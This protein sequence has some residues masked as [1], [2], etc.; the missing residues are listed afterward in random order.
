[1]AHRHQKHK[2]R[3][4]LSNCLKMA[5]Q[6]EQL[7]DHQ[8][9][10]HEQHEA[11]H[12]PERKPDV[13]A[14]ATSTTNIYYDCLEHISDFLNFESLLNVAQS[15]RRLQIGAASTA[16]ASNSTCIVRMTGNPAFIGIRNAFSL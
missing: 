2:I 11:D 7:S 14:Q 12:K 5:D 15:C 4:L 10:L 3:I 13:K 6:P 9:Q 8:Q 16:N 1:M